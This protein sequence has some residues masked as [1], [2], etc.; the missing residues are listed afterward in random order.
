[1]NNSNNYSTNKI[2]RILIVILAGMT[3]IL[4]IWGTYNFLQ[5]KKYRRTLE[6]NYRQAVQ[7]TS[8]NLSNISTDLVKAMYCGTPAQLSQVSAK[9]WKEA[10][11]AKSAISTLPLAELHL[12]KTNQF[13]SQVGDYAMYLSQKTSKG[14]SID[15]PRD[16]A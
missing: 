11:S 6:L 12:D 3:A 1:M 9:L 13:L 2:Q 8:T 4:G 10:S 15:M 5:N 16:L 7:E 14:Q